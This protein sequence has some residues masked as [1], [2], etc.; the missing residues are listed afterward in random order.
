VYELENII[1][2]NSATILIEQAINFKKCIISIVN[3]SISKFTQA[4]ANGSV[5]LTESANE[6]EESINEKLTQMKDSIK[7]INAIT[8]YLHPQKTVDEKITDTG[9]G[10]KYKCVTPH[11]APIEPPSVQLPIIHWITNKVLYTTSNFTQI[12][13]YDIRNIPNNS[14][15]AYINNRI[16]FTGGI[17]NKGECCSTNLE[18]YCSTLR[19]TQKKDM[20]FPKIHHTLCISPEYLYT[21]TGC[22]N[23]CTTLI[24][25]CERYSLVNNVWEELP[26]S[27]HARCCATSVLFSNSKIY[28][29][30]GCLINGPTN[31]IESLNLNKMTWM[32]MKT[33]GNSSIYNAIG[34]TGPNN[35]ILII[36]GL[37]DHVSSNKCNKLIFEG[38][39][40]IYTYESSLING[41]HF[42]NSPIPMESGGSIYLVDAYQNILKYSIST[43]EWYN[44]K[45]P[46]LNC[47]AARFL[48]II[49]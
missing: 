49:K 36:G 6:L 3:K 27:L 11:E 45:K 2:K 39:Q 48:S 30:G 44:W 20:I 5:S 33:S 46:N 34:V 23:N 38:K 8:K 35:S 15:S 7:N 13:A 17:N 31:E 40:C 42:G 32:A 26:H 9:T 29:I 18:F 4:S 1:I 43:H 28:L 12:N 21:L 16:Y 37:V 24:R 25:N 47:I 41:T 10:I 22:I 19:L 14:K